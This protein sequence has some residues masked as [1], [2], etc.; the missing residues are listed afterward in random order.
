MRI[1]GTEKLYFHTP[2]AHTNQ[3]YIPK[4]TQFVPNKAQIR[5]FEATILPFQLRVIGFLR[6]AGESVEGQR[7][8]NY[9]VEEAWYVV[10]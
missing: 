1:L 3:Q 8:L 6:G 2:E 5:A 10:Y 9:G 4:H 7:G